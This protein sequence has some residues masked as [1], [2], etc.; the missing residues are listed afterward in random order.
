[1]VQVDHSSLARVRTFRPRI[2]SSRLERRYRPFRDSAREKSRLVRLDSAP[3][4]ITMDGNSTPGPATQEPIHLSTN[5]STSGKPFGASSWKSSTDKTLKKLENYHNSP[6]ANPKV[7]Y[8]SALRRPVKVWC[9]AISTR[10]RIEIPIEGQLR[11]LR[12]FSAGRLSG[13]KFAIQQPLALLTKHSERFEPVPRPSDIPEEFETK[14]FFPEYFSLNSHQTFRLVS[15]LSELTKNGQ[16]TSRSILCCMDLLQSKNLAPEIPFSTV[17]AAVHDHRVALTDDAPCPDSEMT[18]RHLEEMVDSIFPNFVRYSDLPR[19]RFTDRSA[20]TELDKSA[21]PLAPGDLEVPRKLTSGKGLKDFICGRFPSLLLAPDELSSMLDPHGSGLPATSHYCRPQFEDYYDEVMGKLRQDLRLEDNEADIVALVEPLKVRT[22]SI[23]GGVQRAFASRIQNYLWKQLNNFRV[24]ELTSGK[25]V[26]FS[27]DF[28]IAGLGWT[29]GDY[30]GATDLIFRERTR[31]VVDLLFKKIA[32]DPGDLELVN[33][34]KRDLTSVILN[35]RE[36]LSGAYK[37]HLKELLVSLFPDDP[38][39]LK[40]FEM[41][42]RTDREAGTSTKDHLDSAFF[43][44]TGRTCRVPHPDVGFQD[45]DRYQQTRGQLMGDVLSFPILCLLNASTYY[46]SIELYKKRSLLETSLRNSKFYVSVVEP[47]FSLSYSHADAIDRA[48]ELV[49]TPA[50]LNSSQLRING[51]DIIFQADPPFYDIWSEYISIVGFKK[52]VGKNYYSNHFATVNSQILIPQGHLPPIRLNNLWWSGLNPMFLTRRYDLAALVGGD[53][54]SVDTRGFL[55][56]VQK[57]FLDSTGSRR[58]VMNNLFL[59]V[60]DPL[61]TSFDVPNFSHGRTERVSRSL[62]TALGGLGLELPVSEVLTDTQIVL[63]GRLQMAGSNPPILDVIQ[64]ALSVG[65]RQARR[66]LRQTGSPIEVPT[67]SLP[68][69]EASV[70]YSTRIND[71]W[72]TFDLFETNLEEI[73]QRPTLRF[74]IIVYMVDGVEYIRL[75][76]KAMHL[77]MPGIMT[78]ILPPP[79]DLVFHQHELIAHSRRIFQWALKCRRPLKKKLL[80]EDVRSYVPMTE[81]VRLR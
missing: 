47:L 14:I 74:D 10:F 61:I 44:T 15:R 16:P 59:S 18:E 66:Y 76:D 25:T 65:L 34:L 78:N 45:T 68:L 57:V 67:A 23:G 40:T 49:I 48:T 43:L 77:A 75:Q 55:H 26:E 20:L 30:K 33:A 80:S 8:W 24:F 13:F 32:F 50:V 41:N 60:H 39:I 79:D 5:N 62:P 31:F 81:L 46:G 56:I 19:A 51:D 72:A 1:M 21:V 36:T 4:N 73:P 29:S 27:I 6:V 58:H 42:I 12:D 54:N 63:A 35:Y 53:A 52:S 38:D 2:L 7:Y 71:F 28:A 9:D 3:P 11:M 64:P 17:Q 69:M 70:D 37:T 22:I